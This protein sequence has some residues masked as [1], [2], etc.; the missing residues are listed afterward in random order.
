[1]NDSSYKFYCQAFHDENNWDP[2]EISQDF[3]VYPCCVLHRIHQLEKTFNDKHLD[4]LD[5]FF[6]NLQN[7]TTD[8]IINFWREYIKSDNFNNLN[9]VPECCKNACTKSQF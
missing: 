5:P 4:S 6:N 9:T 7:R 2:I 3:M 8:E 1:M